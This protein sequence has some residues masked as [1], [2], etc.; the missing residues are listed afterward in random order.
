MIDLTP[1]EL[2]ER[3]DNF[4]YS[5]AKLYRNKGLDWEDLK[6]ESLLGLLKAGK[7]FLP[8][9]DVQFTTYATYWIKKQI[10]EA[11]KK[12]S[13]PIE[14]DFNENITKA[15]GT[16]EAANLS[17]KESP[18]APPDR[19]ESNLSIKFTQDL[20]PLEKSILELSFNEKKTLKEI[21][22]I[23][24]IS[25]ERVNQHKKKALRRLKKHYS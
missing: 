5:I 12:T 1:D 16:S 4:A 7:H 6:Q 17:T 18:F 10:I 15:N 11:L 13:S 25:V 24:N 3:Y 22:Q 14:E 9:K 2:I 19:E 21:A 20:P 23:L 8:E